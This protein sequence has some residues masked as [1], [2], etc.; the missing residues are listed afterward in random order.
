MSTA[1]FFA[2][3]TRSDATRDLARDLHRIVE[4]RRGEEPPAAALSGPRAA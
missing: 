2:Y 4:E 1:D 3:L